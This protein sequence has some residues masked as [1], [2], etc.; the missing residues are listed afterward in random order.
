MCQMNLVFLPV[1]SGPTH[2]GEN[3]EY[4]HDLSAMTRRGITSLDHMVQMSVGT[5]QRVEMQVYK[6][7]HEDWL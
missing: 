6:F 2:F 1:L 3:L 4:R 7:N 5:S